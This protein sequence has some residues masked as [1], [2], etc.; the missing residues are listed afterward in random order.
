MLELILDDS[1]DYGIETSN[2][3]IFAIQIAL[4]EVLK[5]HGAKPAAVV[6]QS[7]GEP[8]S[9]Y[10]AGGLSL[11]DATRVICSRS[12][13]MG[14]G[15]AMLFGEYIRLMALVEYSADEL[16]TVFADFPDLEVC[17]YAAPSQT[18]IGGPPAQID[19]IVARCE[20][21]GRFARKLQTKGAG[22]TSQMDPLLGEFSAE[23]QGIAP[24]SPTAAIF[25]TSTKGTYVRP[26][27]EPIHDVA[28]WIKGMRHSVYF[29]QGVR[30]AVDNGYTTFLELAPNPVALMQVGLTTAAAGLPDAQLIATLA[31]KQDDV[32][33]MTS[34]MAQLFVLGH[35]L[36]VRT[37][38]TASRRP[39]AP[40]TTRTS[41]RPDSAARS[42]GSTRTSPATGRC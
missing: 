31:R 3:T 5:H 1:H 25:S 28:Y 37:F 17:V 14:E 34:A 29:T 8:A 20:A 13:L 22:H 11:E 7:L 42:T 19:A 9:A 40:R 2:V 24:M 12:H 26:G 10:F 39:A 23:L 36:D 33:A 15:E 18:V 27:G 41:R 4:G 16:K 6:G 32:D 35:D 38:F 21:E 30:N